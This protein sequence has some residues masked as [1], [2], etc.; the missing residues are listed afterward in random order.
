MRLSVERL[1]GS[2]RAALV[3]VA[4]ILGVVAG[5][6]EPAAQ[7]GATFPLERVAEL[8][9]ALF[10]GL[11]N[12]VGSLPNPSSGGF[13]YSLNPALGV[14]TRTTE[15]FGPIFAERVETTGRGTITINASYNR[16]TFDE[17]DGVSPR[18]LA[19]SD[20][21]CWIP[22][23]GMTRSLNISVAAAVAVSHAI[24]ARR[25]RLGEVGDLEP[26]DAGELKERFYKLSVKQR[27]RIFG[28]EEDL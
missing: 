9:K 16:H 2:G 5:G 1:R 11:A 17:V 20:G 23:R 21:T 24:S 26:A 7:E 3:S 18:A 10:S 27:S 22:M 12:Q 28:G 13:T 8:R 4:V 14:F 6:G 15:S 25:A 19:A